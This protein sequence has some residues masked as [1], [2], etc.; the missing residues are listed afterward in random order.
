[1]EDKKSTTNNSAIILFFLIL[2]I[3]GGV[4][5]A[6][7]NEQ[8]KTLDEMEERIIKL[9]ELIQHVVRSKIDL[10]QTSFQPCLEQ[11]DIAI[12]DV[13]EHLTGIKIKG[14]MLNKYSVDIEDAS[15]KFL[16]GRSERTLDIKEIPAGCAAEFEIYIPDVSVK[17][18]NTAYI[19]DFHSMIKY[20]IVD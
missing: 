8:Q 3:A 14:L 13:N 19:F 16:V 10:T 11:F 4:L 18:A 12:K 2:L 20:R 9:E 17:E 6:W 5:A 7:I 15:F 1:M